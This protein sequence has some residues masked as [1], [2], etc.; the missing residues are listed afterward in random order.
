MADG[1]EDTPPAQ[2]QELSEEDQAA[3]RVQCALRCRQGRRMLRS[4]ADERA[5]DLRRVPNSAWGYDRLLSV[6]TC[7]C[8]TAPAPRMISPAVVFSVD[9]EVADC[10]VASY[11]GERDAAGLF[12]GQGK[13]TF[14]TGQTYEGQWENGLMHGTGVYTWNNGVVYKGTVVRGHLTGKAELRWPGGNVY[15]G[16]TVEGYREGKGKFQMSR[17]DGVDEMAD[18]D[19][20]ITYDGEWYRGRRHGHGVL[21]YDSDGKAKYEGQWFSD[22]RHGTGTM[23]Y[24]SG[25]IYKG[26][27][28]MG[29]PHGMGQM[30]WHSR[31]EVYVGEWRNGKQHGKGVNAWFMEV[32]SGTSFQT[33]NK[34][35][36]EWVEG[37]RHGYGIFEYADGARYEGQWA[38]NVKHGVGHHKFADGSSYKGEFY[39]DTMVNYSRPRAPPQTTQEVLIS[40]N[41]LVTD[42]DD[43]AGEVIKVKSILLQYMSEL[44]QIFR[45]YSQNIDIKEEVQRT[46]SST[47]RSR[48]GTPDGLMGSEKKP[49]PSL[50]KLMPWKNK[51]MVDNAFAMSMVDFWK[52][53]KDCRVPDAQLSLAEIDRIFLLVDKNSND[54]N[55]LDTVHNPKR[56]IIF[57]GFLEGVV[58]LSDYKYQDLLS[59]SER[60]SHALFHNIL[61]FACHDSADSF[62][63]K[64]DD[65]K[66]MALVAAYEPQLIALFSSL[67]HDGAQTVHLR[68]VIAY[69]QE[70]NLVGTPSEEVNGQIIG[71]YWKS[72]SGEMSLLD[73]N[74]TN[75]DSEMI[76]SEFSELLLRL[77]EQTSEK[78]LLFV[79][80]LQKF[81]GALFPD[82]PADV[83]ITRESSGVGK[84]TSGAL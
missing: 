35:D 22:M 18:E 82:A 66:C 70:K 31:N 36:G 30:L 23:H 84:K 28:H 11:D 53:A 71:L 73:T 44:K 77:A 15:V 69:L 79:D 39:R 47:Y 51:T 74:R 29:Q 21:M 83:M 7:S 78:T 13:A 80:V 6:L 60:L 34:Y 52:F 12:S 63:A 4:L 17:M 2:A 42:Q 50:I 61:P 65:E 9:N 45:Y 57:R 59:T 3:M 67:C 38:D 81:F 49:T 55:D 20:V 40:I 43:P 37:Q 75:I 41:D 64:M 48:S 16:A 27:W 54:R 62:K 1:G 25:N 5:A 46:T 26:S 19:G 58:R 33:L 32:Q 76:F 8:N 68:Q 10:V 14:V 72:L 24:K 56:K